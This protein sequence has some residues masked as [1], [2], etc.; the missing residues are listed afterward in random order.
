MYWKTERQEIK[1][2][3]SKHGTLRK[4]FVGDLRF[5]D[6]FQFMSSSLETLVN[7]MTCE[8][9]SNFKHFS[10]HFKD[11]ET[12]KSLLRKNVYCYDYI[13]SYEKVATQGSFLQSFEKRTHI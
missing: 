9:F 4:L 10:N 3:C 1:S 11:D 5:I 8:G 2:Y 6:S 7:N 13:D 12:A